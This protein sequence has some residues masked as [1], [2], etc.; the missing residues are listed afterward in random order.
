VLAVDVTDLERDHLGGAQTRA[1]G[2]AQRRL[3]LEP[4]CRILVGCRTG[5]GLATIAGIDAELRQ[6]SW[7]CQKRRSILLSMTTV[8]K[9]MKCEDA[10]GGE[11]ADDC[12]LEERS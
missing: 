5:T 1:I 12:V 10:F 3:V 8:G 11:D 6:A 4:G 9:T 2:H 7:R